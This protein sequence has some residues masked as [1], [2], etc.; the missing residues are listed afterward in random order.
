M[1]DRYLDRIGKCRCKCDLENRTAESHTSVA[2]PLV[3]GIYRYRV[4]G[5]LYLID[6]SC[7]VYVVARLVHPETV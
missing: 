3:S 2:Y 5:S 1:L 6:L 7:I 4:V